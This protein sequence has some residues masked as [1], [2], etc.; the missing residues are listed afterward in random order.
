MGSRVERFK[1]LY[2]CVYR[3]KVGCITR[4]VHQ[5]GICPLC[6]RSLSWEKDELILSTNYIS[7]DVDDSLNKR[8]FI[9]VA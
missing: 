3:D 9:A 5:R 1:L 6:G 4:S 7:P 2:L 8:G